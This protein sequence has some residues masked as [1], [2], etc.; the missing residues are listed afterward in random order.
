[1]PYSFSKKC[2]NGLIIFNVFWQLKMIVYIVEHS[3]LFNMFSFQWVRSFVPKLKFKII[4]RLLIISHNLLIK[5]IVNL[6]ITRYMAWLI[7][8]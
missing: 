4:N 1:M 7:I 3:F 6:F 8:T 5:P 2:L